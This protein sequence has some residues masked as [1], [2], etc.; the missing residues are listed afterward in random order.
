MLKTAEGDKSA[1]QSNREGKKDTMR[2]LVRI[3][4]EM[5]AIAE[6]CQN[7]LFGCSI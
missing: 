1:A 7:F 6:F 5:E 4:L 3:I 2:G